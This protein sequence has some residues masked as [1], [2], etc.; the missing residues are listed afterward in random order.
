M[1]EVR[2]FRDVYVGGWNGGQ[3]L[4]YKMKVGHKG[5]AKETRSLMAKIMKQN[6]YC[7]HLD[8]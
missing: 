4:E 8:N 5:Q 7:K 6:Q 2:G 1:S 3:R